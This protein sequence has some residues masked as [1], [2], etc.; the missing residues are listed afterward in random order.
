[1]RQVRLHGS[2]LI[3]GMTIS[4][5]AARARE[6]SRRPDGTFGEQRRSVQDADL[7]DELLAAPLEA[8]T[9]VDRLRA[10]PVDEKLTSR[11]GWRALTDDEI[12]DLHRDI[13]RGAFDIDLDE[14]DRSDIADD[15]FAGDVLLIAQETCEGDVGSCRFISDA[16]ENSYATE[17]FVER[18][19]NDTM[20]LR[21][22]GVSVDSFESAGMSAAQ[23][24]RDVTR[25]L[26]EAGWELELA[27]ERFS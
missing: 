3:E 4:S 14:L 11:G 2:A 8:D 26:A 24:R 12:D 10:L 25:R 6:A 5:G 15:E 18:S 21:H 27:G 17:I 9:E 22:T 20:S 13:A 23:V 19:L 16:D 7:S 1:M